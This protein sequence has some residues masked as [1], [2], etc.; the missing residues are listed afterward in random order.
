[1]SAVLPGNV[2]AKRQ[3]LQ[4]IERLELQNPTP[5]SFQESRGSKNETSSSWG[6]G[7]NPVAEL[8]GDWELVYAN[9]GTVVTR[10]GFAQGLM[11]LAGRL[12]GF[13]LTDI[14]QS[15]YVDEEHPGCVRSTNQAEFALGP[16]GSWRVA[17][18]GSWLPAG[19]QQPSDTVLVVFDEFGV[20]LTGWLVKLPRQLPEVRTR[21]P[22]SGS[23]Q[24]KG[25]PAALWRT[26]Y[27]DGAYRVGR[28]SSGNVFLFR[29]R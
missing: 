16:F 7:L 14:V 26:S 17:I 4:V 20:Q 11:Q 28:G 10:T 2:E 15:L 9:N 27:L 8:L 1:M 18:R 19:Q 24:Q 29:R 5:D 23:K 22:G 13:G 6:D 25:R 21:L 12:P 3:I